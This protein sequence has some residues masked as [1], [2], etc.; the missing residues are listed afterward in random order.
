MPACSWCTRRSDK[1]N[2]YKMLISRIGIGSVL[3]SR[4]SQALVQHTPPSLGST[5]RQDT[6]PLVLTHI[7]H[8]LPPSHYLAIPVRQV[9]TRRYTTAAQA[10]QGT[11]ARRKT[12]QGLGFPCGRQLKLRTTA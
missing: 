6:V 3:T 2:I 1:D 10:M 4:L 5:P 7:M 9:R 11:C 12:Q 8:A